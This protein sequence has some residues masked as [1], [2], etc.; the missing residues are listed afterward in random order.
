MFGVG[1]ACDRAGEDTRVQDY[2]ERAAM[3]TMRE[4]FVRCAEA[5]YQKRA[6]ADTSEEARTAASRLLVLWD[7]MVT[8]GWMPAKQAAGLDQK[9]RGRFPH[10]AEVYEAPR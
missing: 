9:M 4:A 5:H 1:A 8:F 7:Q 10:L 2:V 3:T 6:L